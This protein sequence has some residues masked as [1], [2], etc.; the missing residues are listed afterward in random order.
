MSV[1]QITSVQCLYFKVKNSYATLGFVCAY[2]VSNLFFGVDQIFVV[3]CLYY[4]RLGLR[5]LTLL[6]FKEYLLK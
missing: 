6:E 5:E 1:L 3:C 2:V 4:I